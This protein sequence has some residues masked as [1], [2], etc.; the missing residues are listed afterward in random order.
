MNYN[1]CLK[2]KLGQ[3][4]SAFCPSFFET[5]VNSNWKKMFWNLKPTG[6][7]RKKSNLPSYIGL[8]RLVYIHLS[9][10]GLTN[11][12]HNLRPLR[13]QHLEGVIEEFRGFEATMFVDK[14]PIHILSQ[15]YPD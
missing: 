5:D 14:C 6:K 3:N 1:V 12:I 9:L 4:T 11:C 10:I 13:L 8:S 2:N 15:F 7:V